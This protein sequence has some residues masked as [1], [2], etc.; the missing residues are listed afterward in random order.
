[1]KDRFDG[2]L[3]IR[4]YSDGDAFRVDWCH[5]GSRRLVDPFFRDSVEAALR[6]PFNLA[7]RQDTAID[8]LVEYADECPGI[9]PTAFICHASRC[10]STLLA[11]MLM[12]LPEYVVASEPPLLDKVLRAHLRL[13]TLDRDMQRRWLRATLSALAQPRAG[14]ESRFVV[15]LD[16]WNITETALMREAFP[17]VPWIFVYRDPLEIAASQLNMPGMQVVPGALGPSPA[18]IPREDALGMS[19]VE[20]V[21]RSVGRI[22][23]AG[24]QACTQLGGRPVHYRE[25]PDAL[26]TSLAADFRIDAETSVLSSLREAARFDAKN[27]YFE[28]DPEAERKQLAPTTELATAV[29]RYAQPAYRALEALRHTFAPQAPAS[30]V[31]P[32]GDSKVRARPTP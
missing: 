25:L 7:F 15:K 20:F 21:A 4:V 3:P 1:M 8:A 10:G 19:R 30:H 2:W 16:A 5:F 23:E 12:S 17:G 27:P 18:L 31:R 32:A 14:G 22:L 11:R 29:E 6:E 26:W 13:P 28:F 9:P 24:H